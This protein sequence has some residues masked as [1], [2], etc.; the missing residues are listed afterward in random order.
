[1]NYNVKKIKTKDKYYLYDSVTSNIL[2][3]ENSIED[4]IDDA[5]TAINNNR[6]LETKAY[7]EIIEAIQNGLIKKLDNSQCDY[8][9]D[10]NAYFDDL[11]NKN[12][13]LIGVTEK[14]NMRCKYCVYGGHYKNERIHSEKEISYETTINAINLFLDNTNSEHVIFN[15]YGGEPFLKF[16]VIKKSVN[17]IS[18][19]VNDYTV[20]ITSNGTLI[21]D[22][23]ID[24]FVSNENIHIYISLAGTKETH[25]KLRVY[26][27]GINGTFA[28]IK[29][30]VMKIKDKDINAYRKRLNFV[31]NIFS[32]NQ[33]F[34]I[35]DFWNKEE[36]FSGIEN[37]PEVTMIDCLEDDGA[38][39][40][41]GEK[42]INDIK[43][44]GNPLGEYIHLLEEKKYNDI[45]VSY[46][47]NKLISIHKRDTEDDRFT[48]SGVCRP[49]IH[50][51]FVN[52]DGD[53]NICENF[54]LENYFGNVNTKFDINLIKNLLEKYKEARKNIC[55]E[56]WARKICSLCYKDIFDR[57]G[58]INNVRALKLCDNEKEVVEHLLVEYCTVL[59]KDPD[60]LN[61]L[62]ERI[63]VE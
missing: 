38:V 63:L 9:F 1:M 22:D 55:Q 6:K 4:E 31:F 15:F 52:V 16:D 25:D 43:N 56:C 42:I 61:H 48:L 32:E 13:L 23:V 53:V 41:L 62:D 40:Q 58:N 36:M 19:K 27:D 54:I 28:Q 10:E 12:H 47:D 33:L 59:E 45:F 34:E 3:I 5:I 46:Y 11:K 26:K 50:K 24:W 51:F 29:R 17:H 30:N 20:V 39:S 7:Q 18:H 21:N 37:I 44:C 49:F 14:C 57:N 2:E 35:R 60:L 8:W